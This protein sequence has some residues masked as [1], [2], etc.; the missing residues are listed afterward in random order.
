MF[1]PQCFQASDNYQNSDNSVSFLFIKSDGFSWKRGGRSAFYP[2][3]D[4]FALDCWKHWITDNFSILFRSQQA[5]APAQNGAEPDLFAQQPSAAAANPPAGE[6]KKSAKDSIM[7]LFGGGG[8]GS[9]QMQQ[10]VYGVP[11]L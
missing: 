6:E 7:A 4:N 2:I 3:S 10:P 5:A 11:G 8:G 1:N 9:A